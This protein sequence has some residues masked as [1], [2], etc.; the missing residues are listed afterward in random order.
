MCSPKKGIRRCL[1]VAELLDTLVWTICLLP[2]SSLGS[3]VNSVSVYGLC[4]YLL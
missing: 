1:F 3:H 2:V 4:V